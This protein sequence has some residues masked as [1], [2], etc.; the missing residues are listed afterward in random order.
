LSRTD[1]K[2]RAIS[3]LDI[4]YAADLLIQQ[5]GSDAVI[6]MPTPANLLLERGDQKHRC[7]A[8]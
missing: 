6:G 1:D 4:W 5:H 3:D 7:A 8:E 2:L